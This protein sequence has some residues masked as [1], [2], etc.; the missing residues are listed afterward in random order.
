LEEGAGDLFSKTVKEDSL[1]I[2]ME[3]VDKPKTIDK[4]VQAWHN[5]IWE[6]G[7]MGWFKGKDSYSK[8]KAFVE[9]RHT[10]LAIKRVVFRYEFISQMALNSIFLN[11]WIEVVLLRFLLMSYSDILCGSSYRLVLWTSLSSPFS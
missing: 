5:Q 10:D 3:V 8:T 9:H 4:Y 11:L 2:D 1:E 6:H 7:F